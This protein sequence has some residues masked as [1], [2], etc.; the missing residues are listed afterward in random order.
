MTFQPKGIAVNEERPPVAV[1]AADV[2]PRTKPSNYPEPFASMM[3]GRIKRPL[4]KL[5]GLTNISVNLTVL[6][7]GAISALRHAHTTQ[8]EFAYVIEGRPTVVTDEGHTELAPGM[9]VG[10]K[11]GTGNAHQLRNDSAERAV[12]LEFADNS[13]GD[14]ASYPDDDIEAKLQAG[15]WVFTHK[16]GTPY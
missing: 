8:D 14:A 2:P 3:R 4:G 11:A 7:P 13:A 10:F 12:Y 15:V 1:M 6:E 5:F 9:C 16:D